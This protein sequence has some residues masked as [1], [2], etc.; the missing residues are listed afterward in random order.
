MWGTINKQTNRLRLVEHI[1]P[2]C[3]ICDTI[4]HSLDLEVYSAA[5]RAQTTTFVG[6]D[7]PRRPN[8]TKPPQMLQQGPPLSLSLSHS[9]CL[10]CLFH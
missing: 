3:L 1:P 5:T 4:S 2:K 10:S 7:C 6:N 8:K 9:H